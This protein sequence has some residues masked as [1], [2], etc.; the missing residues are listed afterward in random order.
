MEYPMLLYTQMI[1][2]NLSPKSCS[3]NTSLLRNY[4]LCDMSCKTKPKSN[5]DADLMESHAS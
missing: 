1:L 5:S 2:G 4:H 3:L